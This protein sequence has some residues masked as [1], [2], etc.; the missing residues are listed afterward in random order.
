ME[1]WAEIRR[2]HRSE[3]MAIKAIA[4][5]LGL[6]R[7]TVR[8]ALA[9]DS[10]PRYERAAAGSRC[11]AFEPAIRLLLAKLPELGGKP[12]PGPTTPTVAL[13]GADLQRQSPDDAWHR[14]APATVGPLWHPTA[15]GGTAQRQ[16]DRPRMA[17]C[18]LGVASAC[19]HRRTDGTPPSSASSQRWRSMAGPS[20][21]GTRRLAGCMRPTDAPL[22]A[23]DHKDY[24]FPPQ[25]LVNIRYRH[26]T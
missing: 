14:S 20:R 16:P 10:P 19:R 25:R 12:K 8:A 4:R 6:A 7:N 17:C 9:A 13:R 23:S 22:M 21:S 11:D 5:R 24:G 18:R 15:G 1:D 2:L 3:G 26:L